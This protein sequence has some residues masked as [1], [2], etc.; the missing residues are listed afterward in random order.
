[1]RRLIVK[2]YEPR[3]YG[4]HPHDAFLESTWAYDSWEEVH[5]E[6]DPE[7]RLLW[8]EAPQG[9]WVVLLPDR[10]TVTVEQYW[11]IESIGGGCI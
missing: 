11:R 2:F 5:Q 1:M 10:R 9:I 3:N 6:L 4:M 8:R 7:R